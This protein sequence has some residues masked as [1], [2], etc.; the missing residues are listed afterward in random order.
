M[1]VEIIR[2]I[3]LDLCLERRMSESFK[4]YHKQDRKIN[5]ED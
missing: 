1:K 5:D 2:G 3:V 4:K